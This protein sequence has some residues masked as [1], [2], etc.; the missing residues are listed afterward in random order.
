M[1][2]EDHPIEYGEFEGV[3]PEGYGA[4]IV[5]LWDRGTWTPEVDDIDAALKKGR[6]QVHARRLQA[7]RIVGARAHERAVV[8]RGTQLAA[9][10]ASRRLGGPRRHR[11][12]RAAQREERRRLRRHP[13]IGHAGDLDLQQAG[14]RRRDGQ[15]AGGNH[16]EGGRE[17][18]WRP[19]SS[20][21][22]NAK[23][24]TKTAQTPRARAKRR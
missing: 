21:R 8:R 14:Q 16:S 23:R 11:R 20:K 9:D 7:E 18:G 24:R 12:V 3:I 2:V 10:Q 4:G 17:E 22:K 6:P 5:M 15:N 1:H 13:R 19:R